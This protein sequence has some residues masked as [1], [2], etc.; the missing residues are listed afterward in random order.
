MLELTTCFLEVFKIRKL[1]ILT[2][3]ENSRKCATWF[4]ATLVTPKILIQQNKIRSSISRTSHNTKYYMFWQKRKVKESIPEAIIDSTRASTEGSERDEGSEGKSL[5]PQD[6]S[7][8]SARKKK[9]N[10]MINMI[11]ET[12][13][14]TVECEPV[15]LKLKKSKVVV[16]PAVANSQLSVLTNIHFI[17][18]THNNIIFIY[19]RLCFLSKH[20][21]LWTCM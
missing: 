18:Y 9:L 4:A 20:I 1:R 8:P 21:L 11:V 5:T 13:E 10:W 7:N 2:D 17:I 3:E 19:C 15:T 14:E 6:S 16:H 12:I